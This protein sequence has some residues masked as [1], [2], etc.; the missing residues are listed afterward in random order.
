MTYY[1]RQRFRFYPT[2]IR[3]IT[4]AIAVLIFAFSLVMGGV[5]HFYMYIP[6]SAISVLT[7][8]FLHEMAHKYLAFR[9]GFPA[10]FRAWFQGLAIAIL[11][12]F[13]GFLFAAPGAVVVYGY[14]SK[15]ENG[16]ISAAGPITN[17]TV[18][19]TLLFLSVFTMPPYSYILQYVAYFNLFLAFF[20]L[21]PIPPM[22]GTKIISW[23]P[24]VYALL[25]VISI[26]G[27]L[28]FFF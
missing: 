14:P 1:Y 10:A 21:L 2:E 18:G 11:T 24:G 22:D 12:S 6:I 8:F 5:R 19:V 16:I 25:L 26:G 20:N 13:F 9:F 3:D 17:I 27:I 4:I 23:N 7:G 15:R 28:F